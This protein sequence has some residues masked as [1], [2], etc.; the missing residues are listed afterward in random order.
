[1]AL[2]RAIV[3]SGLALV[4]GQQAGSMKG[5]Q[6]PQL[7]IETCTKA[8]GCVS[9]QKEVTI[10]QNWRWVHKVGQPVNCYKGSSWDPD[11]CP[12]P[13]TCAQNCA[14]GSATSEYTST[15]GVTASGSDLKL[16]F[17][18]QGPY[19]KNVGS[20]NYLMDNESTYFMFKLKN[21]EFT[22]DVDVSK[23]PCG[24][25]GALYFVAMEAD[26]GLSKE[27]GN[28]AGAKY[29]TG[30][31][32]AQCPHD[33]KFINGEANVKNWSPTGSDTGIGHYGACCPEMD[34]WEANSISTAYTAHSCSVTAHTRC[35]G[36]DCGDNP[37]HR[38]DGMCD[39]NGCDVQ[40]YRLGE[41]SFFGSGS[42]F[43]I[44]TT[45][46]VTVV[47]QFVTD[48]G[49]DSGTL[50]EIR[51]HYVQNGKRIETPT[52]KVGSGQF[53]S[54]TKEFCEAEVGLFNDKTNFL[55]K[56]GLDSM[57]KAMEHG[58]VLVL[59]LWDDHDVN[60]LWL[61]SDYPTDQ[62]TSKPGVARGSCS[63]TSGKP[64]D[65]ETNHADASVTFSNIRF[66]EIG[67]TDGGAPGPSPGPAPGPSPSGCPGGSL[68][69]CMNLCPTDPTAFQ[70]CVK[71]CEEKCT[72]ENVV[73]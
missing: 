22:F 37:D 61:D 33:L 50:K 17:V 70:A 60:M 57:D 9:E 58:M 42:G 30:Y 28:K 67:S 8:G 7:T 29:G 43:T 64:S 12:D 47:T 55:E 19:S 46:K 5:E 26:G 24:L 56:G 45:Q 6:H 32:D 11:A 62:P 54:I 52:M 14:L 49:T 71:V 13:A 21:K 39:K 36:T 72:S 18:T 53:N 65:V 2:S 40:T 31:C 1:M 23:L 44:D 35:E 66:G 59:S 4:A 73:V 15:Y 69:A 3:A 25:N 27:P 38:F 41:K 20:R 68:S 63:T 16:G 51:R 34:I 48:S 10:D